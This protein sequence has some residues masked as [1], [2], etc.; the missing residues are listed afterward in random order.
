MTVLTTPTET[1]RRIDFD[2]RVAGADQHQ[3]VAL[4]LEQLTT[5]LGSAIH[6]F[7]RGDNRQKSTALTRALSALTALELGVRGDD[8]VAAALLRIY[9]AARRAVLASVPAF[10]R[11]TIATVR[12]DFIDIARA[13]SGP[14]A[15][16]ASRHENAR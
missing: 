9:A 11:A 8:P 1:Y 15:P 2:A 10:D 4:C 7:D 16:S 14:V 3:L 13:L 12:Q 5:A 6:A